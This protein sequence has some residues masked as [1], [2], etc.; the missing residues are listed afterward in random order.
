MRRLAIAAMVSTL[1]GCGME[2]QPAPVPPSVVRGELAAGTFSAPPQRVTARSTSGQVVSAVPV[3]GAFALQLPRGKWTLAVDLGKSRVA[4]V[5][6]RRSGKP[7]HAF[8]VGGAPINLGTLRGKA[9]S[10]AMAITAAETCASADEECVEDSGGCDDGDHAD[11]DI[12]SPGDTD[13]DQPGEDVEEVAVPTATAPACAG[14]VGT[15][16][17]P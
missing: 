8:V 3:G 1:M 9:A 15:P 7:V 2:Q 12:E 17:I 5:M 6:P 13:A 10:A 14:T 11:V 16:P 4:V